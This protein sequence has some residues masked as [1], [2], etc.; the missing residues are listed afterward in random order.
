MATT[1]KLNT[2]TK[3][4]ISSLPCLLIGHVWREERN[5]HNLSREI[6]EGE[7]RRERNLYPKDLWRKDLGGS[8][9][10]KYCNTLVEHPDYILVLANPPLLPSHPTP[11]Y[12]RLFFLIAGEIVFVM[13]TT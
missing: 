12:A 1:F 5:L 11:N 6:F 9:V 4:G 8:K 13:V 3:A 10:I 2:T 7:R